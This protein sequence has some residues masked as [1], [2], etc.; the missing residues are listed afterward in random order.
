MLNF[1][2]QTGSG[3][4]TVVWSFLVSGV[5]IVVYYLYLLLPLR[6][7]TPTSQTNP[8][9]DSLLYASQTYAFMHRE[10]EVEREEE[11]LSEKTKN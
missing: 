7:Q 11:E 5:S 3:A 9:L 1:A 4:V 6:G 2:E 10:K 8:S